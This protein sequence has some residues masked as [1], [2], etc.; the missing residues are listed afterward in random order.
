M[1]PAS[2]AERSDSNEDRCVTDRLVFV[3]VNEE[4]G[5]EDAPNDQTPAATAQ[6]DENGDWQADTGEPFEDG[7]IIT[8]RVEKMNLGKAKKRVRSRTRAVPPPTSSSST[9]RSAGRTA[10]DRRHLPRLD[11][12]TGTASRH[13]VHDRS[14][15]RIRETV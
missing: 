3:T 2:S 8:A 9:M 5:E 7:D 15:A 12:G 10:G 11:V 1:Q 6:A 13:P 14:A 4:G